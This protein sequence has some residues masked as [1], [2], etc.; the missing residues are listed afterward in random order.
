MST[1][2]APPSLAKVAADRQRT[3]QQE[4]LISHVDQ[5]E[6]AQRQVFHRIEEGK[7]FDGQFLAMARQFY[8]LANMCARR[9]IT[10]KDFF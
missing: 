2:G 7:D 10:R 1:H 9:A 4:E 5:L 8:W 6:R 3:V